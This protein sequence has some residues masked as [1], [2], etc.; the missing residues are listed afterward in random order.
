[1][2]IYDAPQEFVGDA[3]KQGRLSDVTKDGTFPYPDAVN[4]RRVQGISP[5]A[6]TAIPFTLASLQGTVNVPHGSRY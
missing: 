6:I 3:F 5:I 1:M 4:M 2:S